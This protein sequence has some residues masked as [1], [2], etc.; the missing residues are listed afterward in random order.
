MK[1]SLLQAL[2]AIGPGAKAAAPVLRKAF[3]DSRV[4]KEAA[5]A[6]QQIMPDQP[7]P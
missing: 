4:G 1:V 2:G 7:L 3:A 6:W 5:A